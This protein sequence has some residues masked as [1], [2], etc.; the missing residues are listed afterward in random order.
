[1]EIP[2]LIYCAAGNKAFAQIA[3]DA[4]FLYGAQLPNTIYHHPYFVDQ[5]WR[6][7]NRER[8]INALKIYKPHM[9]S[10]LD[11]EHMDQLDEVL[12]WAE[13]AAPYVDTVLVVPK[14]HCGGKL[15]PRTIGG[16]I[17]RLGYSVPTRHGG[18]DLFIS[19]FSGWNIHL[20]GG[21]PRK[22][23]EL[24]R[25]MDVRSVD[26]NMHQLMATKYNAFFTVDRIQGA[27]NHP[28]PTLREANGKM[29][30]DGTKKA[31]APYEAFRRSCQNIMAAWSELCKNL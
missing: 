16:K 14:V 7:P 21:S 13:D 23:M 15:L 19:E 30:G 1:M 22:Q 20:L 31:D 6:N 2:T 4:G 27:R 10:V 12:G 3:I 29:W 26:G 17:V 24:T 18:T 8:Y 5:D 25:Y 11:W 28:W 9:A